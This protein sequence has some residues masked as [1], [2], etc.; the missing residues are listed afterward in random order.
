MTPFQKLAE[1]I[2]ALA[3]MWPAL[4]HTFM[5]ATGALFA[6]EQ[7][8]RGGVRDRRSYEEQ[9]RAAHAAL[10]REV[11]EAIAS[12]RD[13]RGSWVAGFM[14]NSAIMR[15][16][17]SYER[18]L[19]AIATELKR[20]GR[21]ATSVSTPGLSD[22]E[23]RARQIEASLVVQQPL[24]RVRL[25]QNRGDVNRLKHRLF[26]REAAEER[27]RTVGDVENA[28]AALE[29]LLTILER[30]EVQSSLASAYKDLPPA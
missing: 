30:P 9:D 26:G 1:R 10:L 11:T 23:K 14:Y 4:T 6:L 20:Q 5:F 19:E 3:T 22:T 12:L 15:L 13:P 2:A 8:K 17:A 16:D 24:A 25:E 7:A 29:E 28:T 27:T 21:L 18:F